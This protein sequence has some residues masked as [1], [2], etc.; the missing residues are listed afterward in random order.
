MGGKIFFDAAANVSGGSS[1]RR[2][3]A[4]D[5]GGDQGLTAIGQ[6]INTFATERLKVKEQEELTRLDNLQSAAMIEITKAAV[7]SEQSAELGAPKHVENQGQFVENFFKKAGDKAKASFPSG[8]RKLAENKAKLQA[9]FKIRGINFQAVSKGVKVKTEFENSVDADQRT[10][11]LDPDAYELVKTTQLGKINDP[12]GELARLLDAETLA[13]LTKETT[14]DLAESQVEGRI[15]QDPADAL[16]SLEAGEFGDLDPDD[17]EPLKA[18][19]KRAEAA[20]ELD[21]KQDI[22]DEKEAKKVRAEAAE[23]RYLVRMAPGSEDAPTYLEI[24]T[25]PNLSGATKRVLETKR[26]GLVGASIPGAMNAALK[27]IFTKQITD[28]Q[29][30]KQLFLDDTITQ[31]EYETLRTELLGSKTPE[32]QRNAQLKDGSF[33]TV[34]AVLSRKNPLLGVADPKGEINYQDFINRALPHWDEQ[35]KKGVTV[36]ELSDP[37]GPHWIGKLAEGLVRSPNEIMSDL[38]AVNQGISVEDAIAPPL[39]GDGQPLEE[40]DVT[41]AISTAQDRVGV[42]Y[43]ELPDNPGVFVDKFGREYSPPEDKP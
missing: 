34:H 41:A 6:G 8:Q 37:N 27:G 29:Q 14:Q 10:L 23:T 33:D 3:T 35:I 38:Y 2:L 43:Y 1:S 22:A 30:L 13:K 4:A 36:A 26:S 5:L 11:I 18:K 20:V 25:D 42:I 31:P 21:R 39:A 40:I 16:I 28:I 15:Q 12:N 24:A 17:I 7:A 32:G 19:A 9:H